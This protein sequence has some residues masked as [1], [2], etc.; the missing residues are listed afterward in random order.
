MTYLLLSIL[1]SIGILLIF[2]LFTRFQV[3][4]REA[5]MVNYLTATLTGLLAFGMKDAIM[6]APWLLPAAALGFL[7]YS[8]F[9]IM[10]KVTQENGVSISS[11]VTKMSVVVPVVV[12]LTVLDESF[13][14]LKIIGVILGLLSIILSAGSSVKSTSW[15]WLA[16]LFVGSGLIDTSLQLIQEWTVPENE[17]GHFSTM[18]FGFAFITALIHHVSIKRKL[19]ERPTMIGGVILG[20]VNFSALYF[21]LK[22]LALPNWES[23]MVFPINNFGIIAGSTLIALVAFGERLNLKGWLSLI[24]AA[25]SILLLYLSIE[26]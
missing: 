2:K 6:D 23:S 13:N 18:V 15:L 11:I 10:A 20:I 16:I 21:I 5:I 24:A 19:P 9:R 12:G 8:V 14:L 17:F 1:S 25:V 3:V 7:F 22:A 4:T 26:W